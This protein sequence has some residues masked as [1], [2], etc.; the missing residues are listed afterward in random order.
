MATALQAS[1]TFYLLSMLTL[2]TAY[3]IPHFRHERIPNNRCNGVEVVVVATSRSGRARRYDNNGWLRSS[4]QQECDE[5]Q[6]PTTETNPNDDEDEMMIIP[7]ISS[8]FSKVKW[9]RK[10]YLMIQDVKER[11]RQG[12]R[13]APR[14]AQEMVR[15]MLN[16]YE[17][18]G[19]DL[20][21]KPTLQAYN[22]WIHSLARSGW[23][24]AGVLAEEILQEMKQMRIMPN[25]VT[26][27]SV[28][29]AHAKS[30]S[31]ERAEQVLF[32]LIDESKNSKN[33]QISSITCDTVL[34]AWAQQG[35]Y[36]AA[37]RA[38]TILQRL[39]HWQQKD[40]R[41]TKISYATGK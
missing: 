3:Y 13:H 5:N 37:E 15:R 41:P 2:S 14:K 7:N 39:E 30:K 32:E 19:G 18:S 23:D 10:R 4:K 22:L 31:P 12:D 33:M 17:K 9:K 29:D 38:Q 6:S 34:N 28:M 20:E 11:I 27:T 16:L 1:I 8:K 21:F 36:E 24:N 40:I 26:Y 35:S 25:I